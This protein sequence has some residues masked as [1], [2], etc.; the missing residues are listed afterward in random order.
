MN[1]FSIVTTLPS[2]H[3]SNFWVHDKFI[4]YFWDHSNFWETILN[5]SDFPHDWILSL[6]KR[7]PGAIIIWVWIRCCD[8]M[9]VVHR[10]RQNTSKNVSMFE[11]FEMSANLCLLNAV[12]TSFRERH[13]PSLLSWGISR[14]QN[15]ENIHH[16][17]FHT[18]A[19]GLG[20][21]SVWATCHLGLTSVR[22]W[23][24]WYFSL[25]LWGRK[26]ACKLDIT[27]LGLTVTRH[28]ACYIS[29]LWHLLHN[30]PDTGTGGEE[31]G[32]GGSWKYERGWDTD[33]RCE[34]DVA[35]R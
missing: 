30:S 31:Q 19:P 2:F 9:L 12:T 21:M 17:D 20:C 34:P 28:A 3:L 7:S 18:L 8:H 23:P 5:F 29:N 32:E 6:I 24:L 14:R 16:H 22:I 35:S 1:I 13:C 27:C 10:M 25:R 33:E 26:E 11:M 15:D 4:K